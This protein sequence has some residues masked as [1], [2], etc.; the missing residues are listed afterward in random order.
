[1]TKWMRTWSF[2]I[3]SMVL[4]G[5]VVIVFAA[6][7]HGGTR[8]ERNMEPIYIFGDAGFTNNPAVVGGTGTSADPYLIEGWTIRTPD[9]DYGIYID[10]TTSHFVIRDCAVE[11]TRSVGIYLNSA[12]NGRIEGCTVRRNGVGIYLLHSCDNI[13]RGNRI[14]E[15][16]YGLVLTAH[17]CRNIGIDNLWGENGL[18]VLDRGRDNRFGLSDEG[19]PLP[20]PSAEEEPLVVTGEVSAGGA[21][22][23][24]ESITE[25]EEGPSL[26]ASEE[27][28]GDDPVSSDGIPPLLLETTVQTAPCTLS[29][30]MEIETMQ[31]GSELVQT[32]SAVLDLPCLQ[33]VSEMIVAPCA[34]QTDSAG[35]SE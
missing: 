22:V 17:S 19:T 4:L 18:D 26:V 21:D 7:S 29:S 28:A 31:T 6:V 35:T 12:S 3:L 5:L 13:L 20:A 34:V 9:A 16:D 1:M 15:N 11:H 2:P 8:S 27:A 30:D 32:P 33:T 14:V 10:H 24:T 23:Q 25:P